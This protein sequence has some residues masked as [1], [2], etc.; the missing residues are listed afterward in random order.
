[1]NPAQQALHDYLSASSRGFS[2][3]GV[4]PFFRYSSMEEYVLK[5]GLLMESAPFTDELRKDLREVLRLMTDYPIK[6]CFWN[7]QETVSML[8]GFQYVEGLAL[9]PMVPIAIHHAWTTYKGVIVDVTWRPNGSPLD[10]TRSAATLVTHVERNAANIAYWGI[11]IAR[12]KVRLRA[13]SGKAGQSFLEDLVR[14][15]RKQ[16]ATT[17]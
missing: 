13:A 7:A 9:D 3:L 15:E 8:D 17:A 1:M 12:P 10:R 16:A 6:Q 5:N 14:A 2:Q 11:V 4:N